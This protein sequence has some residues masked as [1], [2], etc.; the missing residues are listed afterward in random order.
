MWNNRLFRPLIWDN[1]NL[2]FSAYN[3]SAGEKFGDNACH[4]KLHRQTFTA[5]WY[6]TA[7][8]IRLE[9]A[10][11]KDEQPLDDQAVFTNTRVSL[12]DVF[13]NALVEYDTLS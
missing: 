3:S 2:Y 6:V 10:S 13:I 7:T 11:K 1:M 12:P 4:Y 9:S 8:A 5:T